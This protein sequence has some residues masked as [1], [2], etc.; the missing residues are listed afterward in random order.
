VTRFTYDRFDNVKTVTDAEENITEYE[1]N[2][3]GDRTV[4]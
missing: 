4:Q 2:F 1:Y 3:N